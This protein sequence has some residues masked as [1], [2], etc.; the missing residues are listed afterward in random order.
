MKT[1]YNITLYVE[2]DANHCD[3]LVSLFDDFLKRHADDVAH[4]NCD[5]RSS[6][7]RE[8][9]VAT[10]RLF[11]PQVSDPTPQIDTS[12][13]SPAEVA[14]AAETVLAAIPVT[15]LHPDTVA[16]LDAMAAE[17]ST[18]TITIDKD[19]VYGA[20][21]EL[22]KTKGAAA[23]ANALKTVGAAKFTEVQEADY[24]AL[25]EAIEAAK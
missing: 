22:V 23:A 10:A 11:G 4:A 24:P 17:A 9:A 25:Y 3:E 8:E 1:F 18:R 7:R 5:V 2:L 19:T 20:L 14:A 15:D 21:R 12:P 13:F 6:F 16:D